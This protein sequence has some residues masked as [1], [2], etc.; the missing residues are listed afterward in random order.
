MFHQDCVMAR[1]RGQAKKKNEA[2]TRVGNRVRVAKQLDDFVDASFSESEAPKLHKIPTRPSEAS[3]PS[4][5]TKR[6][7]SSHGGGSSKRGKRVT[8]THRLTEIEEAI[9]RVDPD[10][11]ID[12]EIESADESIED[13]ESDLFEEEETANDSQERSKI[14]HPSVGKKRQSA[15]GIQQQDG[16]SV[17][18]KGRDGGTDSGKD[19]SDWPMESFNDDNS[20]GD[21]TAGKT[22]IWIS[23]QLY[24]IRL[25]VFH[26]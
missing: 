4:T 25:T 12:N 24:I 3:T 16:A 17:G 13:N 2:P 18:G 20:L 1:G 5:A 6:A 19:K 10:E 22:H 8:F 21:I 23:F 15:N 11:E 9:E 26:F 7:N 14:G